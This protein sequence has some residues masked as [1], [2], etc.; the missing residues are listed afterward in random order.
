MAKQPAEARRGLYVSTFTLNNP[1][2]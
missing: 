1:Q 2:G